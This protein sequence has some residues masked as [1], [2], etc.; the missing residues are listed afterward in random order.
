VPYL[1]NW[2]INDAIDISIKN[3]KEDK[4]TKIIKYV[5]FDVSKIKRKKINFKNKKYKD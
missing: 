4:P 3:K 2:I 1:Y 5:K